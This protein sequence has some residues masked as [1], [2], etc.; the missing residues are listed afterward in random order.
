[1]QHGSLALV[2]ASACALGQQMSVTIAVEHCSILLLADSN[3][4]HTARLMVLQLAGSRRVARTD[5]GLMIQYACAPAVVSAVLSLFHCV[6]CCRS[7]TSHWSPR[8]PPRPSRR[9]SPLAAWLLPP[10]PLVAPLVVWALLLLLLLR[11]SI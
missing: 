3:E 4:K 8:L 10:P 5:D 9:P 2:R 11:R 7:A 1:V 6:L